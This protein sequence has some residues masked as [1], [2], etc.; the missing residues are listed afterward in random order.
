M[1]HRL[2]ATPIPYK[3]ESPGSI[4]LRASTFNGYQSPRKLL[5]SLAKLEGGQHSVKTE[6]II[7]SEEMINKA[8]SLL[9]VNIPEDHGAIPGKTLNSLDHYLFCGVSVHRFLIRKKSQ[10][11]P[12]CIGEKGYFLRVWDHDLVN[13]CIKHEVKLVNKCHV[14]ESAIL[15]DREHLLEC[16]CGESLVLAPTEKMKCKGTSLLIKIFNAGDSQAYNDYLDL[17]KALSEYMGEGDL[18]HLEGLL[19][20]GI[21]SP[22]KLG[23]ALAYEIISSEEV[24][25]HPRLTF[26]DFK[27]S[28]NLNVRKA[29][30]IAAEVITKHVSFDALAHDYDVSDILSYDATAAAF[31]ISRKQV[32]NLRQNSLLEGL[33]PKP[34][35]KYQISKRSI[36]ELLMKLSSLEIHKSKNAVTIAQLVEDS[37]HGLSL[38]Q[39]IE[40]VLSGDIKLSEFE[41]SKPLLAASV[42]PP[43][44]PPK[45]QSYQEE[46]V[47]IEDFANFTG[48]HSNIIRDLIKANRDIEHF[49]A[50]ITRGPRKYLLP[51]KARKLFLLLI[52]SIQKKSNLDRINKLSIED[53]PTVKV[54]VYYT[55]DS[56]PKRLAA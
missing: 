34:K 16:D 17:R 52:E 1:E 33:Q 8:C 46:L 22:I 15:W 44:L 55:V 23:E 49:N 27:N 36:H 32:Q 24:N 40:K 38:T 14:C 18:E 12:K 45:M 20:M 7:L 53:I 3:D 21:E 5:N 25:F 30:E 9:G 48:F 26:V 10:Y 35:A 2:L 19:E 50:G 39:I 42:I 47:S 37:R 31:G 11:C 28:E 29:A 13:A 56:I 4:L 54:D 43:A 41:W 6:S 51:A